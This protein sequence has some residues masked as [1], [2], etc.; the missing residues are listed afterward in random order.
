MDDISVAKSIAERY[1]QAGIDPARAYDD[2]ETA[3]QDFDLK[4]FGL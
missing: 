2:P 1:E 3:L 4:Q